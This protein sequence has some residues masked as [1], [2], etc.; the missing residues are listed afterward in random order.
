MTQKVLVLP[1]KAFNGRAEFFSVNEVLQRLQVAASGATWMERAEAERSTTQMQPIPSAIVKSTRGRILALERSATGRHDL[2]ARVSIVAGG[3]VDFVQD[4]D[5]RRTENVTDLLLGTLQ[6]ELLEELALAQTEDAQLVGLVID[7]K[8]VAA[9]RHIGVVYMVTSDLSASVQ[10]DEEFRSGV[11]L[12]GRY[13]S[14]TQLNAL[15]HVLDP[16][17]SILV[18]DYFGGRDASAGSIDR[19]RRG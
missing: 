17:S 8:S 5:L 12:S 18:R 19:P 2:R 13:V 14:L 7:R 15:R 10:A 1:R 4:V 3:H 11:G 16:W 6:R 9:S